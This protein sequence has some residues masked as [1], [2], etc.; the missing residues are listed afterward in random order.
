[1]ASG[2]SANYGTMT[3]PLH[4]GNAARAGVLAAQLG[5]RGFTAH[6]KAFEGQA[7]YFNTFGRGLGVDTAPFQ[8]LGSRYDL[9]EIGYTLKA[10]P[11]GG[12]GHTAIEAALALRD[13]LGARLSDIK[14]I[15]CALTTS[16]A[17][18]VGTDYPHSVEAAKFSASYVIAYALVHGA[19]RI[20]AFT[21]RALEDERVKALAKTVTAGGDPELPQGMGESPAKLKITLANGEVLEERRDYATGSRQVPMT[22][23]QIEA[24][25]SDCA[26]QAVGAETGRAILSFLNTLPEQRSFDGL[27]PL[28]RKG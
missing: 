2:V 7:G 13:R 4:S 22:Q 16:S 21:E 18:R 1:M 28:L 26:A 24:K 15:H 17:Y 25:F 19:P 27:W 12:R 20:A 23:V 14:S 5:L 9:V 8:D 11:C 3:K 6:P 10:Y